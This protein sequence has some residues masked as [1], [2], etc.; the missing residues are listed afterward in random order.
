VL[1]VATTNKVKTIKKQ[2]FCKTLAD[3][4]HLSLMQVGDETGTL[5]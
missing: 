1:R 3:G 2:Q 5:L 4:V